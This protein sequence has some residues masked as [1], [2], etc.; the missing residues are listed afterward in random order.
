[1]KPP[2]EATSGVT[3][4]PEPLSCDLSTSNSELP[5]PSSVAVDRLNSLTPSFCPPC[6]VVG[7]PAW[8]TFGFS[9]TDEPLLLLLGKETDK[10]FFS[11]ATLRGGI[12][13]SWLSL[14]CCSLPLEAWTCNN[15]RGGQ[16]SRMEAINL[17]LRID[18]Q[19]LIS[20]NVPP[21]L[22]TCTAARKFSTNLLTKE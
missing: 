13:L 10:H 14:I 3:F 5:A 11:S 2:L 16:G 18:K 7:G 15:I 22:T 9:A 19:K 17:H 12:G 1:M 21:Q 6:C 4:P 20:A 8:L